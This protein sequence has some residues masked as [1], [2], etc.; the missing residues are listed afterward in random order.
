MLQNELDMSFNY[1]PILYKEIKSGDE[2]IAKGKISEAVKQLRPKES[3]GDAMFRIYG[4]HSA[5][6]HRVAREDNVFPTQTAGHHDMWT[7]SG[8]HP[9]IED[10]II[11]QTF[12][13][14]E[15][16]FSEKLIY[17]DEVCKTITARGGELW[18]SNT[19]TCLNS[20]EIINAQTFPQDY[21]FINPTQA[22]I[23][24]IC[25]M[26]VPPIMIKRIVTRLIES[27]VFDYKI[28]R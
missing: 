11:A 6:T 16:Y 13:H 19:G 5:L 14:R 26:F 22:N 1:E 12:P 23:R 24:Y 18:I 9:S 2:R 7:E 10:M 8:N 17:E 21:N 27:G 28:V 3:V 20:K 4:K 25:G 15:T